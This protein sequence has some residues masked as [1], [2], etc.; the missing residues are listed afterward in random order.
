MN[1]FAIRYP[2]KKDA[3]HLTEI[4]TVLLYLSLDALKVLKVLPGKVKQAQCVS[5]LQVLLISC[6]TPTTYCP[7]NVHL[8]DPKATRDWRTALGIFNFFTD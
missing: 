6:P 7:D 3:D 1:N 4:I 2:N 5:T 8:G